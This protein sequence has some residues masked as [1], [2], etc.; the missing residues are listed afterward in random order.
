[1]ELLGS[2][3]SQDIWLGRTEIGQQS[4]SRKSPAVVALSSETRRNLS[5]TGRLLPRRPRERSRTEVE[6]HRPVERASG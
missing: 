1:M 3:V 6:K 5:R 4:G 2:Q